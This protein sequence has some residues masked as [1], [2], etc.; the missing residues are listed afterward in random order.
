MNQHQFK[1]NVPLIVF[2][3]TKFWLAYCPPLKTYGYSLEGPDHAVEDFDN[4]I[5]TFLHVHAKLNTLNEVFLNLG[6]TRTDDHYDL[7][8][9]FNTD[10]GASR[11]GSKGEQR[12]HSISIPAM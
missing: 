4:A 7:P 11:S 5:K 9:Y 10:I 2:K 3:R 1:I 8:K 6:W 12:N